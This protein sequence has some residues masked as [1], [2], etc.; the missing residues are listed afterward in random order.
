[1]DD[2]QINLRL[3][4]RKVQLALGADVTVLLAEDGMEAIA[5]YKKLIADGRQH[6]LCGIFMDYH[7]PRCSGRGKDVLLLLLLL[8]YIHIY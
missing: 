3:A 1:V 2:S 4:K 7:M 8:Y 5:T 6:M